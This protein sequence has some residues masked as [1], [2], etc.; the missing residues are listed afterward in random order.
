[1]TG[2]EPRILSIHFKDNRIDAIDGGIVDEGSKWIL[3]AAVRGG[4]RRNGHV[5]I[6]RKHV[7]KMVPVGKFTN[8]AAT[9]VGSWPPAPLVDADGNSVDLDLDHGHLDLAELSRTAPVLG[10]HY[11][12]RKGEGLVDGV[13]VDFEND[14]DAALCFRIVTDDGRVHSSVTELK[15]SALI[16][17]EIGSSRLVKLAAKMNEANSEPAAS[18]VEIISASKAVPV[19]STPFL[20]RLANFKDVPGIQ[21]LHQ[22]GGFAPPSP[23]FLERVMVDEN[24]MVIVAVDLEDHVVAWAKTNYIP[25]S[26]AEPAGYYLTGVRVDDQH[27]RIGLAR[28][29][30]AARLAWLRR[31]TDTVYAS[32][33]APN[34]PARRYLSAVGFT[35]IPRATPRTSPTDSVLLE[36]DF[37]DEA[38]L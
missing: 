24:S 30:A 3:L 6:R 1:M 12:R 33:P 35:E 5:L 22:R 16:A 31:R 7:R 28:E 19:K 8:L 34:Q 21:A 4:A 37:T 10:F 23:R 9:V 17:L 20:I 18:T 11:E 14:D 25:A 2:S 27:R 36:L 13:P 32:V 29:M 26:V 15:R 38:A